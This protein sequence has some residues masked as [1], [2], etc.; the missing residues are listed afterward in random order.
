MATK[1]WKGLKF[2]GDTNCSVNW[3]A[4]FDN[5]NCPGDPNTNLEFGGCRAGRSL[6]FSG[7]AT[8]IGAPGV[9]LGLSSDK[10]KSEKAYKDA[11]SNIRKLF[12]GPG[13]CPTGTESM[14]VY[15]G[16]AKWT[17]DVCGNSCQYIANAIR[18]MRGALDDFHIPRKDEYYIAAYNDV[19]AEYTTYFNSN[20]INAPAPASTDTGTKD[21]PAL[22]AAANQ[23]A[24]DGQSIA[25]D[26]TGLLSKVPMWAW[27]VGG[28]LI[29]VIVVVAV[30]KK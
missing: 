18:Y 30:V 7:L 27:W 8:I 25:A 1:H 21:Q 3:Q 28:G 6:N 20:C 9:L 23:P 17:T 2:T 26:Q 4:G 19:I 16:N 24:V 22:T 5:C 12:P 11:M 13:S 14:A 29:A 15:Q 10:K